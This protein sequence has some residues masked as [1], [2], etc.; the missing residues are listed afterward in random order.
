MCNHSVAAI[1]IASPAGGENW[2]AGSQHYI[3][4]NTLQND[5]VKIEYTIDGGRKWIN[6][7]IVEAKESKYL[8]KIPEIISTQCQIKIST[9]QAAE[10]I[11]YSSIFSIHASQEVTNYT[12]K[13][14]AEK[15]AFA[16]R[17]GAGA[18]VFNDRMWLLGGWGPKDKTNFPRICNNEVWSSKDG[19]IWILEKP[20]TFINDSFDPN[21]DWEG[22]HYAGYVVHENKMWIIGGDPNQGHYQYD[23]W[24]ST[25][26][27]KWHHVNRDKKIPWGPRALFYTVVFKNNIWIM[28]GQTMPAFAPAE[29]VFYR[30]IWTTWDGI[31]WKQIIPKEPCWTPRGLMGGS[32]VFKDRIWILGGGTYSTPKN[33]VR[34]YFSDVWSS[35]DGIQWE[36]HIKSAPWKPRQFHEV[37]VFDDKMWVMEGASPYNCND[38]WYSSDGVNWYELPNTPWKPRHAASVFVHDNALWLVAGN[39]FDFDVRN[40]VW[41]L[42]R[43]QS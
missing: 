25:D 40:D 34:N 6:L 5:M 26:G 33:P 4:W 16:P 19:K 8:W 13:R 20:N 22:R 41:K 39:D 17:D 24:N 2:S 1:E 28:G 3:I 18:L 27:K 14:I 35:A 7:V 37:A 11:C 23:V 31:N 10:V 29:E 38:V 15:A 21:I 36:C 12:W 32:V 43:E 30:D 9:E 42:F